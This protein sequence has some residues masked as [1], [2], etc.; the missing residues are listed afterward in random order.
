MQLTPRT[1]EMNETDTQVMATSNAVEPWRADAD[2]SQVTVRQLDV[3]ELFDILQRRWRW[4]VGTLA[5]TL[6]VGLVMTAMQQRKYAATTE[7]VIY[8]QAQQRDNGG[9]A[10]VNKIEGM[11]TNRSIRT[12]LRLLQSRDT[13]QRALAALPEDVRTTGFAHGPELQVKEPEEGDD[14]IAVTVK[15]LTPQAAAALANN[16]V[17]VLIERDVEESR[18]TSATALAYVGSELNHIDN[19]LQAARRQLAE[20]E[21]A[22]GVVG[23]NTVLPQQMQ[24]LAQL[25]LEADQ[26]ARAATAAQQLAQTL[27]ANINR[28]NREVPTA[29]S[30]AQNPILNTVEMQINDLEIR[31]LE[32]LQKFV[33]AAPEVTRV[34]GELRAAREQR[35][36]LL[37]AQKSQRAQSINPIYQQQYLAA[38]TDADAARIRLAVLQ[39]EIAV[40]RESLA[41]LPT[42]E[43]QAAELQ[44]RV[45][46][47]EA[48]SASLSSNY[49]SLRVNEASQISNVRVLNRAYE[50]PVPVSPDTRRNLVL[51][52]VLGILLAVMVTVALEAV[53]RCSFSQR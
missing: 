41:Q 32:L 40:K 52:L 2:V 53:G 21:V 28:V 25:Q 4:I 24:S 20:F 37:S 45:A 19:G 38:I 5:L 6:A 9:L 26:A 39:R 34:E 29:R 50:N 11:A 14:V 42:L 7:I 1:T 44:N 23:D 17:Q 8:Q 33:P 51:S 3:P 15:A 48:T 46:L 31:R 47:L 10:A 22:H 30:E 35:D 16:L 12:Q 18:T 27:R 49:Q 36:Q 43:T 13:L